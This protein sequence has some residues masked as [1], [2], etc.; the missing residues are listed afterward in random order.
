MA[1]KVKKR[2]PFWKE[3]EV[4]LSALGT[5]TETFTA[6]RSRK[7]HIEQIIV[8]K[9]TTSS[10]AVSDAIVVVDM[11]DQVNSSYTKGQVSVDALGAKA[12]TGIPR[13]LPQ[14]IE[15]EPGTDLTFEFEDKS[16]VANTVRLI[17]V[18]YE[19]VY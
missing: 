14:K 7:V 15:V 16:N 4:A 18:G 13:F 3:L 12:N 5:D 9:R 2:V 10:L 19:E 8:D 17:L 6:D 11:K 1:K